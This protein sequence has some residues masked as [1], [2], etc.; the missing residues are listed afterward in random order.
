MHPSRRTLLALAAGAALA[1]SLARAA[2]MSDFDEMTAASRRPFD[3]DTAGLVRAAT[4][5]A[6]NH[7]AQPWRFTASGTGIAILPD[8]ARRTPVVD[9][10]DH[11]LYVSLG[12]A[13]ENLLLTA[14]AQGRPGA[15]A[16]TP[17]RLAI[18]LATAAPQ[19]SPLADAIPLRQSTRSDYDGKPLTPDHLRQLEAAATAIP[20]VG[21]LL[22]TDRAKL[23]GILELVLAGNTA[24]LENRAFVAELRN[25]MRFNPTAAVENGDGLF[26]VLTGS[27]ALP[28]WL[29]RL[30]FPWVLSAESENRKYTAQVRS[31]AG[32]AVFTGERA[33]PEHWAQVGRSFQRFALQATALGIRTAHLNQPV[34]VAAVRPELA[35]RLGL[36]DARPDL[37]VRFGYAPAMP[38]SMRRPVEAVLT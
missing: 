34:E 25:W 31:S 21:L 1:P 29:G 20:G 24:Q 30:I 17:E 36:G 38:M 15:L 14:A 16:F 13:A 10:E 22:V 8:L 2:T 11:H 35:S 37:V 4:L 9:P 19:P 3:P 27:P 18:D 7:N 32:I 28:T 23:D 5:A 12:A 6:N 26:S 33:D